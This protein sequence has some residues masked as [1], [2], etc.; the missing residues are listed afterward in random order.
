MVKTK[1]GVAVITDTEK[2]EANQ[3]ATQLEAAHLGIKVYFSSIEKAIG[4]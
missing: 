2:L 1:E 4:L 3:W